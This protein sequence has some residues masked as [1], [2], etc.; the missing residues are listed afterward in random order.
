MALI[1]GTD[2]YVTQAEATAY[3]VANYATTSA[4]LIA[5]TALTSDNKDAY[6]RQARRAIDRQ[7]LVGIKAVYKQTLE[8]PRAIHT[9]SD[10]NNLPTG[11]LMHEI[12]WMIQ[13]SVPQSVKDAQVEESLS[14]VSG[15][16]ARQ[17]LQ[18][19]GVKSF[20]LGNLSESYG[21]VSTIR[22]TSYEAQ[23]LM[24]EFIVTR[25]PI[26]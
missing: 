2:S 23:Q 7:R 9:E 26:V 20:S 5:W 16:S 15:V 8:F 10:I 14:L 24:A 4:Q 19:D 17:S 25:V 22:L 6:L 3:V 21:S 11:Y 13:T 18:R 1:V 12:G